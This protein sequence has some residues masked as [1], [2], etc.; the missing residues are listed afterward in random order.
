MASEGLFAVSCRHGKLHLAED[1]NLFE[2]DEVGDGLVSP[3]VSSFARQFQIIARYR[4][5]DL[6]RLSPEPCSCGSPLQV[7]DEVVG[8]MDDVFVFQ[9]SGGDV[10]VTP[11]IIRNAVLNA[12]AA[13]TDFRVERMGPN[14]LHL[15]LSLDCPSEAVQLAEAALKDLTSGF[16]LDLEIH[17]SLAELGFE[18]GAK[19]RRIKDCTKDAS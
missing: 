12:S 14:R 13:I 6:L 7:V 11:D 10:I 17:T 15:K 5:N 4:M 18:A 9:R 2:F 16:S 19:L 1:A 8:R 3:I